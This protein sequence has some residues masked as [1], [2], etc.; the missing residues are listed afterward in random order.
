MYLPLTQF[1]HVWHRPGLTPRRQVVG[2]EVDGPE[3]WHL[4]VVVVVV[5]HGEQ[6]EEGA[7]VG[8]GGEVRWVEGGGDLLI[9]SAVLS[10]NIFLLNYAAI[11]SALYYWQIWINK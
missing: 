8:L 11:H 5:C 9:S 6:K 7:V 1:G 10:W 3:V 4:T 2:G